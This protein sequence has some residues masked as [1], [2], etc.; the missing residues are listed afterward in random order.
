MNGEGLYV[1]HVTKRFGSGDAEVVAVRDVSL[2]V[3]PGEVV[4]IMGP[5]GSGK[6]TLLMMLGALL[7]RPRNDRSMAWT[8]ASK[9]SLTPTH[10]W[11][12]FQT[13]TLSALNVLTMSRSPPN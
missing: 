7:S 4:L 10:H 13:S 3:A 9:A 12:I 2:D 11:F 1:D 6:T 8:G 5:S